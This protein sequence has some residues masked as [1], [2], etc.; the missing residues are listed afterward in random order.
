MCPEPMISVDPNGMFP[1][2]PC[3]PDSYWTDSTTCTDCADDTVTRGPVGGS[4]EESCLGMDYEEI[5]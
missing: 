2:L 4:Y 1:C 3:G 5:Q